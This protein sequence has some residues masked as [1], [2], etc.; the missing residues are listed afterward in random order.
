MC[1]YGQ[2]LKHEQQ[3]EEA[4]ADIFTEIYTIESTIARAEKTQSII[5]ISKM[6]EIIAKIFTTESLL[7]IKSLV[8]VS[9][10]KIFNH[11]S[12]HKQEKDLNELESRITLKTNTIS[13][14]K[15]LASFMIQQKS[16][17]F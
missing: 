14:K 2:D 5:E 1:E 8:N 16:Y 17:P 13:L 3:L 15:E 11:T 7:R 12:T 6:S 10:N 4:L 9:M